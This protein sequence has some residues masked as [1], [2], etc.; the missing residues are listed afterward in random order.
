[1]RF[2]IRYDKRAIMLEAHRFFRGGRFGTFADCLRKAW[3]NIKGKTDI[4][5][6][7]GE[8]VNTWFGWTLLGRE[9]RHN[10]QTIGQFEAWDDTT[11][12]GKRVKSYFTYGQTCELGTQ[13]PKA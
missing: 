5:K 12:S 2:V 11:K 10:E 4:A 13:P 9:V 3:E 1:M 6:D 7:A 8:P